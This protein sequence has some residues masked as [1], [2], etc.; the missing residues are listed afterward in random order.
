MTPA[1]TVR[2]TW[3][4]LANM[5]SHLFNKLKKVSLRRKQLCKYLLE[6]Y[7]LMLISLH[8]LRLSSTGSYS[9]LGFGFLTTKRGLFLIEFL[10]LRKSLR[11]AKIRI[12]C[13]C[14][15]AA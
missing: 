9:L 7:F 12:S 15:G 5:R 13:W 11:Q 2:H 1:F 14:Q 3:Q 8:I 10:N 4:I 6:I